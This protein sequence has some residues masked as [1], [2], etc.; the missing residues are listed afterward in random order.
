MRIDEG[1]LPR[2]RFDE[3]PDTLRAQLEAKVARLGYLGEFFAVAAHQ[4]EALSG[5]I[6][7]TEALTGALDLRSANVIALAIAHAAGSDYE[8]CQHEQFCVRAGL[9]PT[10]IRAAELGPAPGESPLLPDE[11][12]LRRLAIALFER[13]HHAARGHLERLI[14][15][16]GVSFGVGALLLAAR[17]IA[18]ATVIATVGITAPVPSIFEHQGDGA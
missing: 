9:D 2:K 14:A 18:H 10:W 6:T 7:F 5:F 8:R 17:Y 12:E 16:R 1:A 15:R 11:E 4:P 3:L 13:S